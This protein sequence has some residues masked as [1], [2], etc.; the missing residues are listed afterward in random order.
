MGRPGG[1]A[2]GLFVDQVRSMW[3]IIVTLA[4]SAFLIG[5]AA[6]GP[7]P[8]H[9]TMSCRELTSRPGIRNDTFGD[10]APV[11]IMPPTSVS[12]TSFVPCQQAYRHQQFGE[13]TNRR[14]CRRLRGILRYR[15]ALLLPGACCS[16]PL[17]RQRSASTC[18]KLPR[19]R[20][21]VSSRPQASPHKLTASRRNKRPV[22]QGEQP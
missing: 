6:L 14:D 22:Q 19:N 4:A 11:G 12:R 1:S 9:R 21:E 17:P 8:S 2:G 13:Q 15:V 5:G 3:A 10:A 18:P 16:G 7:R 20:P